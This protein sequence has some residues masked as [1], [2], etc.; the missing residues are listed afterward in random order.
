MY[1]QLQG[2]VCGLPGFSYCGY[3]D[4]ITYLVSFPIKKRLNSFVLVIFRIF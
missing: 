1:R 2:I 3:R 4:L